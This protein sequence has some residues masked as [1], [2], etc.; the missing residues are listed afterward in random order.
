[1]KLIYAL[2][3][4]ACLGTGALAADMP[5][6]ALA[7]V[8]EPVTYTGFFYGMSAGTERVRIDNAPILAPATPTENVYAAGGLVSVSAGYI[9]PFSVNSWGAVEVSYARANT[10]ANLGC[11]PGVTCGVE[12]NQSFDLTFMYGGPLGGILSSLVG[13]S[14]VQFGPAANLVGPS[15][16]DTVHPFILAG[17]RYGQA[18]NSIAAIGIPGAML[19]DKSNKLHWKAGAGVMVQVS[20]DT[21][22]MSTVDWTGG[23]GRNTNLGVAGGGVAVGIFGPKDGATIRAMTGFRYS[24]KGL[25]GVI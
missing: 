17:A 21:V 20:R 1:M 19:E 7:P 13:S 8:V 25:V 15:P 12:R 14:P 22:W 10:D 6:K 4:L 3:G 24:F 18:V 9:R 16:N 5:R 2:A 11:A 23:S